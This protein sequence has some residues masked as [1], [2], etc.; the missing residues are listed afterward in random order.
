LATF[1]KTQFP[2]ETRQRFFTDVYSVLGDVLGVNACLKCVIICPR[3]YTRVHTI[4]ISSA[5]RPCGYNV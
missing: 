3:C 5:I 4:E 2:S 1:T